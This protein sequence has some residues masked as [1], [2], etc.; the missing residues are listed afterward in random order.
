[1]LSAGMIETVP[2]LNEPRPDE[3]ISSRAFSVDAPAL[4]VKGKVS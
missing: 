3:A 2:T 1:M 4:N